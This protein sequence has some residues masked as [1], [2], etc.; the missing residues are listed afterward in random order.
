MYTDI[1]KMTTVDK[2]VEQLI[3]ILIGIQLL[4]IDTEG[5]DNKVITGATRAFNII[6]KM[7]T[8]EGIVYSKQLNDLLNKELGY[9]CY[10]TSSAEW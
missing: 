3:G 8:F 10:S 6:I 9:S 1:N 2:L 7:F 4:K 5:N